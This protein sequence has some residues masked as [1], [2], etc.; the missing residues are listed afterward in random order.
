MAVIEVDYNA[1]VDPLLDHAEDRLHDAMTK[2]SDSDLTP[3]AEAIR[4]LGHAIGSLNQLMGFVD[5]IVEVRVCLNTTVAT[6]DTRSTDT[7]HCESGLDAAFFR[8]QGMRFSCEGFAYTLTHLAQ[9][10]QAQTAQDSAIRELAGSLKD[11]L[12]HARSCR[13]VQKIPGAKDA[14]QELAR[15]TAEGASLLDECMKHTMVCKSLPPCAL[16][17]SV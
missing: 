1:R 17:S 14:V 16:E 15:L 2:A 3:T 11:T 5:G 12:T 13:N 8:L 7:S 9:A 6:T 4:S 10:I